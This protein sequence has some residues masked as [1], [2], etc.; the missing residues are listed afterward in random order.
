MNPPVQAPLSY[1]PGS[2]FLL[3]LADLGKTAKV[4]HIYCK[5]TD[6]FKGIITNVVKE[7]C[8]VF[9][10]E[11][12]V[13]EYLLFYSIVDF[14]YHVSWDVFYLCFW[15]SSAATSARSWYNKGEM[16]KK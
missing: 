7:A 15:F 2:S 10:W 12:T 8:G 16:E 4:W 14:V 6:E 9:S 3:V 1:Q 11:A 13:F 5:S